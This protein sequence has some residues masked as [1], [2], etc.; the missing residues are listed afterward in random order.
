MPAFAPGTLPERLSGFTPGG[1]AWPVAGPDAVPPAKR[2]SAVC[3]LFVPPP[4][5]EKSALVVLTRRSVTVKSHRGQIG[6]AGGRAE[7]D[8]ASPAATALRE[9]EEELGLA[10]SRVRVAGLLAAVAA[11]DGSP[12]IP[13]IGFAAT[14]IADLKP[15]AAEVAYAFA[16]PWTSF[17]KEAAQAFRFNIFGRWR[18]T[19]SFQAG[20]EN[21]WGLTALI[22]HAADLA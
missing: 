5:G 7:P 10:R 20:A 17:R 8:D 15:S 16:V 19:Q 2:P 13:V 14:T 11:L 6:L 4:A 22:L 9:L 21:V 3:L 1:G 18:T 12:V